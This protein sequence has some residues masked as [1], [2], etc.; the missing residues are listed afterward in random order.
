MKIGVIGDPTT[1]RGFRLAGVA[2]VHEVR[3]A[4]EALLILKELSR[5]KEMGL[6]ILTEKISDEI[7]D[8]MNRIFEGKTVPLVV[9]IPDREGPIVKKVDPIQALIRRAVGVEVKFG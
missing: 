7:R 3:A 2:E 4:R 1:A 8:E 6:I 9:E 5:D